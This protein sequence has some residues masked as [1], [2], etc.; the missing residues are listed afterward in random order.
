MLWSSSHCLQ[1]LA[2]AGYTWGIS[3]RQRRRAMRLAGTWC[4]KWLHFWS[5]ASRDLCAK[6]SEEK[7][8]LL[9]PH[10]IPIQ[11]CHNSLFSAIAQYCKFML[12]WTLEGESNWTND[13][14][15]SEKFT[16]L[17]K[18]GRWLA[19]L[20]STTTTDKSIFMSPVQLLQFTWQSQYMPSKGIIMF[21][22]LEN[23]AFWVQGKLQHPCNKEQARR[24]MCELSVSACKAR[25]LQG[26]SAYK[27]QSP[28]SPAKICPTWPLQIEPSSSAYKSRA[29][30]VSLQCSG[31]TD[32]SLQTQGNHC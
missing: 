32:L 6:L 16:K 14:K 2:L 4:T 28:G 22:Q 1:F 8:K 18:Y 9:Q 10:F 25:A 27:S 29:L 30:S 12:G 7:K 20:N 11:C 3:N 19:S 15:Y 17:C 13:K 26:P 31:E 24:A 21:F 5:L 23:I